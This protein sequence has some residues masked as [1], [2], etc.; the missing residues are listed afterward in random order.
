[1]T[2]DPEDDAVVDILKDPNV[3]VITLE[4]AERTHHEHLG[5]GVYASWDGYQIW[6]AANDHR[7]PVIALEPAVMRALVDYERRLA[8]TLAASAG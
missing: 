7:N 4:R 8:Q 1:M 2:E 6:L 3:R 5:D